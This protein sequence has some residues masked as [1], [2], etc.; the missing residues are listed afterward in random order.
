MARRRVLL[1]PL[2]R[3]GERHSELSSSND[4]SPRFLSSPRDIAGRRR[5]RVRGS[6]NPQRFHIL[7]TTEDERFEILWVGDFGAGKKGNALFVRESRSGGPFLALVPDITDDSFS[8]LDND[9]GRLIVSTNK[10]AP[11]GRIVAIDPRDPAESRWATVVPERA[12]SLESAAMAGGRLFATY[13]KDVTSRVY[14]HTLDGALETEMSL[15]GPGT[16]TVSSSDRDSRVRLLHVHVVHRA[17]DDLPLRHRRPRQL[18]VSRIGSSGFRSVVLR[19]EAG[20]RHEQG[21]NAGADVSGAPCG[22]RARWAQ[23]D[24]HVRLWRVQRRRRAIVQSAAPG[25]ARAGF[26]LRQREPAGWQ[27]IRR[28]VA[29]RWNENAE[30]ERVRRLHRRRRVAHRSKYTSPDRLAITGA[31]ERRPAGRSRHQSAPRTVPR[32]GSAG[33]RDGHAAV[34]QVHDRMELDRRLRIER[35]RDGV[36]GV[37]SR[38]HRCTTSAR[39]ADTRRR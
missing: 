5:A 16:A 19:D 39:A 15:P 34:P 23:P 18:R 32:G 25:I 11:N 37:V 6:T 14:V 8:V 17:A 13:I 31:V 22:P 28:N 27:R 30:A 7:H 20:L 26:R 21:R 33:G 29:R 3:A 38:I 12:E 24:A 36:Q 1:Q 10:S 9:G 2:S 4:P 35:Q